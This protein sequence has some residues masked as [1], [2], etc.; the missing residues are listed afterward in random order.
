M[1][2]LISIIVALCLVFSITSISFATENPNDTDGNVNPTTEET[3]GEE[4][5]DISLPEE[6]DN[7]DTSIAEESDNSVD[8][9]GSVNTEEAEDNN[10]IQL[11][12]DSNSV[13][14][15]PLDSHT[16]DWINYFDGSSTY[17]YHVDVSLA[18]DDEDDGEAN[19]VFGV[20]EKDTD[21]PVE[22]MSLARDYYG[23]IFVGNKELEKGK[24]YYVLLHNHSFD[25]WYS[26]EY[27]KEVYSGYSTAISIDPYATINTG[28]TKELAVQ[29][30]PDD[31]YSALTWASSDNTVATVDS[32]GTVYAKKAGTCDITAT[33][34]DG[35]TATCIVT[36]KN[37]APYLNYKSK[38]VYRGSSF[39]LIL[40]YP[41]GK[42]TYKSTNKKIA[43]V[44]SSGVV[45]GKKLGTCTI[46][47]TSKGKTYYCKVKVVRAKPNF[48]AVLYDYNTRSN[49]FVVKVK[50]W[51]TK[52]LYIKK[53]TGKVEDVDYKSFDR[54][55]KLYKTVKIKPKSSK[56]LY[57]KVQGRTT[58]YDYS[59]FTLFYK[60][61]YDGKNYTWHVWDED[62]VMK[63]SNG[64]YST[65]WDEDKYFDYLINII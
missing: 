49:K 3:L 14:L 48:G 21:Q 44:S 39:R 18:S 33:T 7:A 17:L 43:T 58:W 12:S 1:K 52:T 16:I 53:G 41:L 27:S 30:Y 20:Y 46:K 60:F 47:V 63:T 13:E 37:P 6:T 51:G 28:G 19:V 62:S 4:G 24:D 61:T 38:S 57:F 56:T 54:K 40:K 15:P 8:N 34:Q 59:D 36:V 2:K 45:K 35:Y 26:I 23:W 25:Y 50:N 9:S 64:W 5:S 55:V 65:Y 32:M 22:E 42:A 10:A 11:S 31:T 29:F